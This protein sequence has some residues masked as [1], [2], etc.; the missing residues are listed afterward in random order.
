MAGPLPG[1]SPE[2]RVGTEEALLACPNTMSPDTPMPAPGP[3]YP[4]LLPAE[5]Q[6]LGFKASVA[7]VQPVS[8]GSPGAHDAH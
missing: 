7:M 1:P 8:P 2:L 6:V 5:G 4:E 3:V